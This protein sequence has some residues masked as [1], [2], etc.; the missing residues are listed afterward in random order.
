MYSNGRPA[1]T[2]FLYI[3]LMNKSFTISGERIKLS[4]EGPI[5]SGCTI[6][7]D[8]RNAAVAQMALLNLL[9]SKYPDLDF[10]N[11]IYTKGRF[12]VLLIA[13]APNKQAI[14]QLMAT[15]QRDTFL[16]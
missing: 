10:D 14:P 7:V 2:G 5:K 9:S 15:Q 1:M 12:E 11:M 16:N 3:R 6:Y 8:T 4:W 13:V